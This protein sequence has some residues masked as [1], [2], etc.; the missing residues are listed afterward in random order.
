M[1][2]VAP[3]YSSPAY[4]LSGAL[5]QT[6]EQF[7]DQP[8]WQR[9]RW[10]LGRSSMQTL[11]PHDR[12]DR[13][14][15]YKYLSVDAGST[16]S[17][18]EKKKLFDLLVTGELYLSSCDQFNDPNEF[19]ANL[20]FTDD[21]P[22]LRRWAQE[23]FSKHG[24]PA[25]D[26]TDEAKDSLIEELCQEAP[27]RSDVLQSAYDRNVSAFG[28]YCFSRNPRSHLMWAHYARS[29]RGICVQ[30]D[31]TH[32][33]EVF[34]GAQT[35]EYSGQLPDISWPPTTEELSR[36]F[37]RKSEEWSY[38]K[39]I[40]YLSK[41]VKRSGL[42]FDARAVT[43]VIVGQRFFDDPKASDWL[44]EAFSERKRLG[45]A[46]LKLYQVARSSTAYALSLR[47]L[48]PDAVSSALTDVSV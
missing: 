7:N 35:I 19:R 33:L 41:H 34:A 44:L 37:L 25:Q 20:S 36:G 27:L 26:L 10:L 39:E 21:Q 47:R 11:P 17:G 29:H 45:L 30:I 48:P 38:E 9:R 46:S 8:H 28:V 22:A 12:R 2:Y 16:S 43:G 3:D 14:F 15:L 23:A 32:C 40:R 31:P 24:L 13:R 6:I 18:I 42:L 4:S 5:L 1:L